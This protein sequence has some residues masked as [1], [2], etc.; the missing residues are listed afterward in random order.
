MLYY[1]LDNSSVSSA[2]AL[3][4]GDVPCHSEEY[5]CMWEVSMESRCHP[6]SVAAAVR[7]SLLIYAH[8]GTRLTNER[9]IKPTVH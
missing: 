6:R 7:A 5:C 2:S 9:E 1:L 4:L 3:A 8:Q